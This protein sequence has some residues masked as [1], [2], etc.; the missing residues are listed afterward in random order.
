VKS[1][2]TISD[3]NRGAEQQGRKASDGAM[4]GCRPSHLA[5][6]NPPLQHKPGWLGIREKRINDPN[7]PDPEGMN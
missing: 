2:L 7:K 3:E 5:F 1:N 4:R 6:N